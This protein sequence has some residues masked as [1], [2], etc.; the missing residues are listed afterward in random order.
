MLIPPPSG[1][2]ALSPSEWADY[3]TG[4]SMLDGIYGGSLPFE[5]FYLDLDGS[6][7]NNIEVVPGP[8]CDKSHQIA[9]EAILSKYCSN[10]VI[11]SSRLAGT[12][13]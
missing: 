1:R 13:R 2:N 4:G 6:V 8:R 3:L 9:I 10:A 7:L 12:I 11:I 5:E